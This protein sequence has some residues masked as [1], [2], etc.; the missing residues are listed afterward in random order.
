MEHLKYHC[1]LYNKFIWLIEQII[2]FGHVKLSYIDIYYVYN[3]N[4]LCLNRFLLLKSKKWWQR[5]QQPKRRQ[6]K[7]CDVSVLFVMWCFA[8]DSDKWWLQQN[9]LTSQC[10][11]LYWK[12]LPTYTNNHSHHAPIKIVSINATASFVAFQFIHCD[13]SCILATT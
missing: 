12:Q 13:V 3:S 1:C 2:W 7:I 8:G 6:K 5:N 11:T 10:M 4:A 9:E